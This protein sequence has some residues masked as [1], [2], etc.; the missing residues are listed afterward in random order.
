[1]ILISLRTVFCSSVTLQAP[2]SLSFYIQSEGLF[3]QHKPFTYSCLHFFQVVLNLD[4][5]LPTEII[6]NIA[7]FLPTNADIVRFASCSSDLAARI[8]PA[9]SHIWRRLFR[10][11]Y[12]DF[13]HRSSVEYKIEFQIRSIVL[14]RS[15][16]FGLGE[17]EIQT[18]WLKLLIDMLT[19]GLVVGQ[20]PDLVEPKN[21]ECIRNA[22]VGTEFLNRPVSGYM[23]RNPDPPSSLFV[24]IQLILTYMALDPSMSVRCLRTDYDIGTI[25]AYPDTGYALFDD[26][27]VSTNTAL[28]IRNF[29]LRHLLNPDEAC[30]CA[31]VSTTPEPELRQTCADLS[32]HI[33]EIE[34]ITLQLEKHT[35]AENWPELFA[36]YA[37]PFNSCGKHKP[38]FFRGTQ[39]Y[40]GSAGNRSTPVRGF[41]EE[42]RF[43]GLWDVWWHIC[44]VAYERPA[45]LLL[46]NGSGS[47]ASNTQGQEETSGSFFNEAWPPVDINLDFTSVYL[48]EGLV[49]PGRSLIIGQWSDMRADEGAGP[50]IFWS[51]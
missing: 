44:F 41:F 9:E 30:I 12:D 37:I 21:L 25:Y 14:S 29:W 48:Y 23:M 40:H 15:V 39:T 19:E 49:V 31:P 24:T 20:S 4:P 51:I 43:G 3:A 46:D 38:T 10:D 28:D 35:S 7:Y 33:I 1:M 32:G 8:L 26:E 13:P 18:F 16:T 27:I 47:G 34:H 5:L 17:K 2:H 50:F 42:V 6:Q 36:E 45:N 11:A 22:L